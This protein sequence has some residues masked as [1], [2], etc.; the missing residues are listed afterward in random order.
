MGEDVQHDG[1][2]QYRPILVGIELG[3]CFG[4]VGGIFAK[5]LRVDHSVLVNDKRLNAG[6]VIFRRI[7]NIGESTGHPSIDDIRLCAAFGIGALTIQPPEVVAIERL[8][9]VRLDRESLL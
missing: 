8:G 6:I 5:I 7:C 1:L 3:Y 9:G 2:F 4:D